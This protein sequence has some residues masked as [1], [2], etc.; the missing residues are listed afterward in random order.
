MGVR[1]GY[2]GYLHDDAEQVRVCSEG[3]M[4]FRRKRQTRHM[5]PMNAAAW[6]YHEDAA[7][8][9]QQAEQ[10]APADV[11]INLAGIERAR[12]ALPRHVRDLARAA[13]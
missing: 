4:L 10:E 11:E 9:R 2:C 3:S 8:A 12:A 7:R 5:H 13:S 6:R 1:C